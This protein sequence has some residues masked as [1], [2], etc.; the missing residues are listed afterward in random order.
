MKEGEKRC[1]AVKQADFQKSVETFCCIHLYEAAALQ[2]KHLKCVH[3]QPFIFVHLAIPT[4]VAHT[5]HI[6]VA[7]PCAFCVCKSPVRRG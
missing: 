4:V 6:C 2:C 7:Q 3:M 5:V 1:R